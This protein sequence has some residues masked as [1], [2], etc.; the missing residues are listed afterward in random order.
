LP[1]HF[2]RCNAIGCDDGF[3][4]ES[5]YDPV[6]FAEGEEFTPC[7]ECFGGVQ[8]WCPKCGWSWDDQQKANA[9]QEDDKE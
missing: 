4:D 7:D 3:I 2:R 6:N 1:L 9:C 8:R 5:E